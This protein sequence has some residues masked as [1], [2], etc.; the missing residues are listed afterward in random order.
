MSS[1]L[2][3]NGRIGQLLLATIAMCM[4]SSPQYV[5]TL[6]VPPAQKGFGVSLSSLQ[7]TI[8]IFSILMNV[9]GPLFGA[10][11]ERFSPKWTIGVGGL[12]IGLSWVTSAFAPT[13]SVF[14]LTYGVLSGI[15]VGIVFIVLIHLMTLW[16]PDRRGLAV[17]LVAGAYGFGA[18]VTTFP[19]DIA[20]RASGFRNALL[21]Y[22]LVLGG[23]CILAALGLR[24]PPEGHAAALNAVSKTPVATIRSYTPGEMLKTPAF[25]LMFAM[26]TMIG[27]GGLMV[28]SQMGVFAK[29]FGIGPTATV[30]GMATLPFALSIDRVANGVTR[31]AFGWLS[32]RIGRENV[33]ALAF[34]IETLAIFGLMAFGRDPLMFALMT[35]LI[36]FGWGEIFSVFPAALADLFGPKFGGRNFGYLMWSIAVSSVFGGPLA[37]ALFEQT[38]SWTLVFYAVIVMNVISIALALFVLKPLRIRT[39]ARGGLE[40]PAPELAVNPG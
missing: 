30:F 11:S 19:I 5:W 33:M 31:P 4:A 28:I 35:A 6:F 21:V 15:G 25:W 1:A 14:Y 27:T 12:L 16:F 20:I 32:D 8:S 38:Q 13:L 29:S 24:K 10:L 7:I 18:I 3:K 2:G 22:G 26:M 23:V 40:A 34:A 37:S 39:A 9:P 36:F 17:G